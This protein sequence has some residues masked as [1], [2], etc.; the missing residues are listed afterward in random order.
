MKPA[1]R[2]EEKIDRDLVEE[3][4]NEEGYVRSVAELRG[5]EWEAAVNAKLVDELLGLGKTLGSERTGTQEENMAANGFRG[6]GRDWESLVDSDLVDDIMEGRSYSES[7][8][9]LKG[10]EWDAM[11]NADLVDE[12]LADRSFRE[13]GSELK[14]L[15]WEASV[16]TDLVDEFTADQSFKTAQAELKGIE[17][18]AM[19]NADLVDEIL[20]D[21]S[22]REAGS[23]LKGL[24]WE[25]SV[26]ADLVD[27]FTADQSFKTAQAE[28]KGMEWDASVNSSLLQPVSSFE[29]DIHRFIGTDYLPSSMEWDVSFAIKKL[30]SELLL[31]SE[32]C[33][34]ALE[35][36]EF[37][38][39]ID[40][41]PVGPESVAVLSNK[42]QL[43]RSDVVESNWDFCPTKLI[44]SQRQARL[45]GSPLFNSDVDFSSA[46]LIVMDRIAFQRVT[47]GLAALAVTLVNEAELWR[48]A[49]APVWGSPVQGKE[50]LP[51]YTLNKFEM[52]GCLCPVSG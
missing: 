44:A 38:T 18:D 40:F 26:S 39:D 5:I 48:G 13:A 50:E 35:E 22:F 17:W 21:R 8:A 1:E 14:G 28:L 45:R 6:N 12:I 19:V 25:A 47:A 32:A 34:R 20:A 51:V 42:H 37:N 36:P 16:S 30:Q 27:E 11:V 7:Q 3:T 24:E 46:S 41:R 15:E 2:W 29:R 49:L 52:P 33:G 23:E 31:V 10:M 9:E 43:M 4:M